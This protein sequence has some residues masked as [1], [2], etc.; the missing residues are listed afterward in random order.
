MAELVSE[1]RIALRAMG[2]DK[3]FALPVLLTLTLCL[4]ANATMF[5]VVHSVLLRPLRVPEPE[6][7]VWVSNS[8]PNAG[9]PEAENSVPDYFD[10][11]ERVPAFAEVAL[12]DEVG[13][14]LG[15]RQGAE[16]VTG[17]VATPSLFHMLRTPALRG[18][19][20]ED[21]DGE[22]GRDQQV[23][24]A[25]GL[26]QRLFGGRANAV[27]KQLRVNGV[28]HTVIGVLPRGF[29]FVSAE[30]QF[31]L[32]LAF[33]PEERA[34]DQRHSNNYQMVA[35]LRAGATLE[36]AR[37][38]LLALDRINIDR[39]P[40]LR[41]VLL[42]SGYRT[43]AVPLQERLV[44]DVSRSLYLLW[45]G[46][47]AVLLIGAV[48]V[49]NLALVR[50]TARAREVAA[51]QSL[52]ASPRRLLRQLLIESLLLTG[53]AGVAGLGL[54]A[55][56]VRAV[57]PALAERIPRGTEVAL[58]VATLGMTAALAVALG[59]LLALIPFAHTA[60]TDLARTLREEGRSGTAGRSARSLR[61]VLV[62]AQVAFAFVLL[63]GAGLLLASFQ[64][65][66][67]VRPGFEPQGLLTGRV[68]L[69]SASYP[70][71]GAL[72]AWTA[73]FLERVR[74]Q[75]GVAAAALG[76]SPPFVGS[77]SDSVI[78]AEGYVPPPGESVVSPSQSSVTPGYFAALRVPVLR[79]R[80]IDER[81]TATS[82]PVVVV[83]RKLADRFWPGKDPIGRRMYQPS[84]PE[85]VGRPGP[86]TRYVT[87]VGV[88]G[89]VRQRGLA[90][91]DE[92]IGAYYYP[93]AQSTTHSLTLVAR[94]EGDPLRVASAVRRE[95]AAIDPELPLYDVRTM[96]ARVERSVAGQQVAM[97]L[98]SGFALL[99]LLLATLGIYGVLTYQVAQRRREIGIRMALGSESTRVFRLVIGEGAALLAVGVA[100]GLV[101]LFALRRVLAG[102]LYGITP[103]DPAVLAA[104]T[105]LLA[106]VALAAC[107]VP[108]RRASRIDPA[109]ALGE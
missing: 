29:V 19:L 55:A 72:I 2:R 95:L 58:G 83:D 9:V 27:G 69:P 32:P 28:P 92:R 85:E 71:D 20:F 70:E 56:A 8:Y 65:L 36:Q 45:G 89:D 38:Q 12:Y 30:P 54:A 105:A 108:A 64:Q 10:R 17:A 34:E 101:G 49:A 102:Q 41:Q 104:V 7:L 47:L 39:L 93:Y 40:Q 59:V 63:L 44:R 94:V 100:V 35:R 84:G 57:S 60:R 82:L 103:F 21:R 75:P 6:R 107:V 25:Y 14:T 33:T 77:Y 62:A 97:R 15:T 5:T 37:Q 22:P 24:L 109:V 73:R 42:D 18:R 99:A 96:T 86:D 98:A 3:T 50:A 79:G 23:V 11:R 31:F 91:T 1:M 43:L 52:G 68:A 48:N 46:V 81:D 74:A 53:V 13:R 16:R 106:T 67:R 88:V 4:A 66:L 61:R 78:L 90:S 76:S 26:W 87:V 51:R 80:P